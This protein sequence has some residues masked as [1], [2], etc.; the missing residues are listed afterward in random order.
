M[1]TTYW[2]SIPGHRHVVASLNRT[3]RPGRQFL[4]QRRLG[5]IVHPRSSTLG[6]TAR[7]RA[8]TNQT[9]I[10]IS[11]EIQFN[12]RRRT[13]GLAE[14]RRA[15]D[16]PPRRKRVGTG[17]ARPDWPVRA[18]TKVLHHHLLVCQLLGAHLES[19]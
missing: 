13:L 12:P 9:N 18:M 8:V 15:R 5:I 4:F 10:E 2:L 14:R 11:S 7:F 3:C 6:S 1:L 17:C 19:Q 16:R